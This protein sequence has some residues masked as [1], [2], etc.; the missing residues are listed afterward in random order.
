MSRLAALV[1]VLAAAA[2]RAQTAP[3]A[4]GIFHGLLDVRAATGRFDPDVGTASLTV[5]RWRLLVVP[6]SNGLYPD[7]EPIIVQ[8]GDFNQ[9]PLDAG[10]MRAARNGRTFSYRAPRNAPERGI[11]RLRLKRLGDGSWA[12]RMVLS[13]LELS[14]LIIEDPVCLGMAI[15]IGDDDFFTGVNLTRKTFDAKRVRVSGECEPGG[16]PWL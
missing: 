7:Q 12:V 3:V 4:D 9:Y 2:A 6:E 11:R 16:W 14:R 5:P 10:L 1:V 13:E 15:I 8:L